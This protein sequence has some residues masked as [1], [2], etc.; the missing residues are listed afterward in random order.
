MYVH[1]I[2][3]MEFQESLN[4]RSSVTINLNNLLSV[5]NF[6]VTIING[7]EYKTILLAATNIIINSF[8]ATCFWP[9][10]INL[11]GLFL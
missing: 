11:L 7:K 2:D 8:F 9:K 5:N 4:I 3:A 6:L 1:T 10:M